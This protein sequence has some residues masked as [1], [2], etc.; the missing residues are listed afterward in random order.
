LQ[1]HLVLGEHLVV[2]LEAL[3]LQLTE[4][5]SFAHQW[6]I[7]PRCLGSIRHRRGS[8]WRNCAVELCGRGAYVERGSICFN[9]LAIVG[10]ILD[11]ACEDGL[12]GSDTMTSQ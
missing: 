9:A 5:V 10:P 1:L 7:I 2:L 11:M 12:V 6:A 4:S 8:D 3:L